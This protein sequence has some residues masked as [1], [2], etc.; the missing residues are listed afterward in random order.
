M[1]IFKDMA[2]WYRFDDEENAGRDSSGHQNDAV[3]CGGTPPVIKEVGGRKAICLR[4]SSYGSSYMRLPENILSQADDGDG[5]CIAFWMNLSRENSA[6]ERI[7]DFG[8]SNMGPYIFLTRNL[9]ASC[10][11]DGDIAA[12]PGVNFMLNRWIHVAVVVHGTKN[13]TLSSAGPVVYVDGRVM[14]D[15]RASQTSS[16]NYKRLREWFA[17]LSKKGNYINNYIGHSQ[18][19]ADPDANMAITDFRIYNRVLSE[20][21]IANIVCETISGSEIIDIV[22]DRYLKAPDKIIT[23]NIYL[24]ESYMEGK[25]KAAWTSGNE[26]VLSSKGK[27]G[28]FTEP[29]YV[30]L[31]VTLTA[32]SYERTADYYVNVIPPSRVPYTLEIH[33]DKETTD[34]SNTLYGLFYED[35]NNAA[36]GGLYA[37]LVNNRS[38][39]AFEYD[40]YGTASGADARS[41]GRNH[42]PLRYWSGDLDRVEVKN[43][44]GINEHLGI[45]KPGVSEYYITVPDK[46]VLYNR[47]YC[48]S[49]LSLSIYI[50]E[51]VK[52]DFSIWAKAEGTVKE[53]SGIKARLV[54]LYGISMS[55]SVFVPVTSNEWKKYGTEEKYV[56]TAEKT[57][58][59]QLKLEFTGNI[60]ID[61]VSLMPENVW[62]ASEEDTSPTAHKNFL[63]NPN[64]RLRRDLVKVMQELHPKFLRFP[65][66]CISEGSYIWENVYDWKDSVGSIEYR[67]ENYN[68]WGY[69]MT[70]GLGY[71][72]Y[73]QLAEDLGALPL[74]VMACGVLCQARSDYANPAGGSLQEKYIKN[75]TD[76]IDFAISTDF[77]SNEWAALRRDMGHSEPFKLHLL[78]V[79]NENWGEEFFASFEAFKYAIDQHMER[80]YPGYD[81]KII[82]TVGAQADDDAY[83]NGWKFLSGNLDTG[84]AEVEFTDG[85][86]SF[87]EN[88]KWYKHEDNYMET[89][90]DEHYYRPDRYLLENA[91]RYNYYYR[92]YNEDGTLDEDKTSKVFVGEYA[93]TDKNSLAG[94]VA[95]AAIMT[96]FENNSDVVRLAATAPLFNKVLSDSTYRW[97]PDAIWFDNDSV[98]RTPDYYVQQMFA[99][100]IGK[101]SV[102]TT[103]TTYEKGEQVILRPHGGIEIATGNAELLVREV[104]VISNTDNTI[105][106]EQDFARDIKEEWEELPG[107]AGYTRRDGEG[108]VLAPSAKGLNGLYI[109]NDNWHDYTVTVKAERINGNGGIFIG[110]GLTGMENVAKKD[111]I[112]YAVNMDNSLTGIRVFKQGIEGYRL[113]DYSSS[114]TAGNLRECNFEELKNGVAYTFTVNYG[115]TDGKHISCSYTDGAGFD[116]IKLDYKL[117]AYNRA[118][119]YSVTRDEENIYAKLVNTSDIPKKADIVIDGFKKVHKVKMVVLAAEKDLVNKPNVNTKKCEAVKPQEHKLIASGGKVQVSLPAN[120]VSVLVF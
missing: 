22:L 90:A 88:V 66:G 57:C 33:A 81:L 72:E 43:K 24:P 105:L 35:I 14:A 86:K 73:F 89:I 4:G 60:S 107:F 28:H 55:S 113:G 6:W 61:L 76:L 51:G 64:Y 114:V 50:E 120:S 45:T 68:V 25:V 69:M 94:A 16:G 116:S 59:V 62:G 71:M 39:E 27:L 52:Y 63:S 17:G 18:F 54:D 70:M 99:Q 37:E 115:G 53:D 106:F 32:G 15:G 21:E 112:E 48:D 11:L 87:V 58:Y 29:A 85:E 20:M 80:N 92:A 110:T 83:K 111:V 13:G 9:R 119:Y 30:K 7:F 56:F 98:W 67:R 91:D 46:A 10:F 103:F 3:A 74:P 42:T 97:T 82:S 102:E 65:G 49:N 84:G 95:E 44:G 40:T 96:G 19:A 8:K 31:S 118:I 12:D 100:Y 79:G 93:S 26:K 34:I 77:K 47:G 1:E 109:E 41:T 104:Q 108:I 75:F 101:K 38:F 36:D 23:E 117:E 2:A 5:L 78:G